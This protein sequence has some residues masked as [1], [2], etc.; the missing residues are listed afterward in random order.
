MMLSRCRTL[1][2]GQTTACD[3]QHP[4]IIVHRDVRLHLATEDEITM[5]LDY[6]GLPRELRDLIY[7][8]LTISPPPSERD[9][10]V[11]TLNHAVRPTLCLVSRQFKQE[12]EEEAFRHFEPVIESLA[13][14]SIF[15]L[16]TPNWDILPP[17]VLAKTQHLRV[18]M[19]ED[20]WLNCYFP[21]SM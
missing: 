2:A 5:A 21:T 13:S 18:R 11:V 20:E 14:S 9:G 10:H 4:P 16:V 1:F 19:V 12:Y 15:S 7:S 8:Q 17:H 3:S 6:F